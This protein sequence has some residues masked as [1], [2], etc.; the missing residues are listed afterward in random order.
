[1]LSALIR[2]RTD[3]NIRARVSISLKTV[4]WNFS[5]LTLRP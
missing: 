4:A 1:M 5:R 3:K 2:N